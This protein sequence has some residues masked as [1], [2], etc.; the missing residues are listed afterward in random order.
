MIIVRYPCNGLSF[1]GFERLLGEWTQ[2]RLIKCKENAFTA[3]FAML[4]VPLG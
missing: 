2:E 3:S 4:K 1:K